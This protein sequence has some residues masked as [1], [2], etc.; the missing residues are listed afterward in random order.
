LPELIIYEKDPMGGSCGFPA[1]LPGLPPALVIRQEL[2]R[3]NKIVNQLKQ[4]LKIS[5]KR[6][7]LK[8]ITSLDN[9]IVQNYL[10]EKGSQAFPIF[11]F[12]NKIIH[13]ESFPNSEELIQK[14][15]QQ[16]PFNQDD[17]YLSK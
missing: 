8:T 12:R 16:V 1:E 6:I 14:L 2:T 5:I 13:A 9:E 7:F 17:S 10:K 11:L 4:T 15:R 3:R